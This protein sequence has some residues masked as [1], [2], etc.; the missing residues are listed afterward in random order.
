VTGPKTEFAQQTALRSTAELVKRI[1]DIVLSLVCLLFCTPFIAL[2]AIVLKRS[3]PGP[4]LYR[5]SRV[6]RHGRPFPILKFRTMVIDAEKRG[7][8]ATAEDDPRI[9]PVGRLLRRSKLDELPQLINVLKGEMS[10]VG[11]RPEVQKY[12]DMYSQSERAILCLRPGITDWASIWNSNEA[13]VLAG[14]NDPEKTY[15]EL[16]RPTKIA[17]QMSY[18]RKHS[19]FIDFK[20]LLHT[21]AKLINPRWVPRE[22]L[23]YGQIRTYRMVMST[24]AQQSIS[25]RKPCQSESCSRPEPS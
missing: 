23:P 6:G 13:A 1:F 18:V 12:V 19:L 11:P 8:S 14:S 16:I 15:E 5:G 4:I 10:F 25:V 21:A 24:L 22:L 20:I 17:L 2:I 9:V 7:G 3:S